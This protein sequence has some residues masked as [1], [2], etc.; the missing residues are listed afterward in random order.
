MSSYL[1]CCRCVDPGI[2]SGEEWRVAKGGRE[3]NVVRDT[4]MSTVIQVERL[5]ESSRVSQSVS[6]CQSTLNG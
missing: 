2:A 1:F 6:Q 4:C 5:T 3:F